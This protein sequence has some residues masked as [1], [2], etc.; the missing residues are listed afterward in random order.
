MFYK[1][2]LIRKARYWCRGPDQ[3]NGTEVQGRKLH[4]Y[5]QVIFNKV[6]ENTHWGGHFLQPMQQ[7]GLEKGEIQTQKGENGP[8]AHRVH[9]NQLGVTKGFNSICEFI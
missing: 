7:T 4:I 1:V 9:K 8:L 2:T 6:A 3:W 5:G